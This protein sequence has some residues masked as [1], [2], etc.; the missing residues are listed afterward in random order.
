VPPSLSHRCSLSLL[1]MLHYRSS[2][3]C[4]ALALSLALG[5]M[6]LGFQSCFGASFDP[7]VNAFRHHISTNVADQSAVDNKV[8]H[9]WGVSGLTKFQPKPSHR[10]SHLLFVMIFPLWATRTNEPHYGMQLGQNDIFKFIYC[11][12]ILFLIYHFVGQNDIFRFIYYFMILF[13]MYL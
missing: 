11:S 5:W 9:A 3:H 2:L 13:L 6:G 4:S 7:P 10:L 12:M 8:G 1:W